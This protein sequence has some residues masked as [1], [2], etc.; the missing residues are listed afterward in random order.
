MGAGLAVND[1]PQEGG[2]DSL[3]EALDSLLP[4]RAH[5]ASLSSLGPLPP[6]CIQHPI[7][8][9]PPETTKTI[10]TLCYLSG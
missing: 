6:P 9:E 2:P 8:T 1:R 4:R 3:R 5:L 10:S 7:K